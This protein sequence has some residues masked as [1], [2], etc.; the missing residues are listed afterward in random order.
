MYREC[1]KRGD[2]QIRK[3]IRQFNAFHE[4]DDDMNF[5]ARHLSTITAPTL[6][7]HGDRDNF[8]PVEIAVNIYNTIPDAALWIIPH[9]DHVPIFNPD[10]PF[11]ST[12]LKY[13]SGSYRG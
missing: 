5:N 12:I 6:I 10:I 9:G 7:V 1:A 2:E 4:N 13:L 3:L 8:F 11:A